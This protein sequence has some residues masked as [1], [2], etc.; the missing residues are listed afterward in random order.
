[1]KPKMYSAQSNSLLHHHILD[2]FESS[3]KGIQTLKKEGLIQ[4][5][6]YTFLLEKNI[7]RLM[8]RIKEFRLMER[9]VCIFFAALFTYMQ[10][11]ADDLDMV[12][13]GRSGRASRSA[14]GSR[15]GRRID[16][17]DISD[18]VATA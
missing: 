5:E 8:E 4:E 18:I 7:E 3:H 1:M 15:S 2:G 16:A 11:A 6:E 17:E 10:I 14:R 13:R 12:R 9:L